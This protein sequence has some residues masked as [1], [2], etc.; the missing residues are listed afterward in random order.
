MKFAFPSFVSSDRE[1]NITYNYRCELYNR[2][3]KE[4]PAGHVISEFLPDVPWAGIYNTISCAASHHFRE[5]RWMHDTAPLHEYAEFWCTTGNPRL[6]SFPISDSILALANVTGDREVAKR[7]YPELVRIYREW[8]DHKTANGMYRQIDGYDGGE[9]SISG[10]GV[11]PTINSYMT[12]DARALCEIA[13]AVGDAEGAARF[14]EEADTLARRINEELW[15]PALGMYSVISDG[16]EMRNV[17]ELLDYI[18]WIYGIPAEGRGECFRYLL[19]PS[20]FLAPCGLRTADASHPEYMKPF[21]HEC[22]WNGPV[23]PFATAQTLTAMIEYLQTAEQPAVTPADFTKL[24]LQYAYSH[25]DEDGSP[26]L[27]ENMDPDTGIWL[28]RSILREWGR[29]DQTR[30]RHYNHSTFID[31]VMTGICGIRPAADDKLVIRPLGTSLD[32]FA[33]TDVRY[34]GHTV[35]IV[36]DKTEGLTVTLDGGKAY[37]CA[38]SDDVRVEIDLA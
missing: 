4:T 20:C 22:L 27:D 30:G 3:I 12:A 35:G 28:A 26:Y 2:H 32:H 14:R 36:W 34:H 19:D 21:H 29:E 16:G 7:L 33:V 37:A 38:A 5:G 15:N 1:L 6:Y 11:R 10:H 9:F 23:W 31:L 18:P 8:D 24:L 25:R 17:R 13:E